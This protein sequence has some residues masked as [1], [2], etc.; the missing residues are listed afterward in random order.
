MWQ[1]VLALTDT[2]SLAAQGCGPQASRESISQ[3]Q[4]AGPGCRHSACP[5]FSKETN[6]QRKR[7]EETGEGWLQ[8][9]KKVPSTLSLRTPKIQKK[10][11]AEARLSLWLLIKWFGGFA[12]DVPESGLT[13]APIYIITVSAGP[14]RAHP[15]TAEIPSMPLPE[16]RISA[17][18]QKA[19]ETERSWVRL[20]F[21]SKPPLR[22]LVLPMEFG[23]WTAGLL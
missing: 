17:V 23:K 19:G 10:K 8:G 21:S 18:R 1:W 2:E 22:E 16:Y 14:P 6:T 7:M 11:V 5:E 12:L 20:A 4:N 3:V 9:L 13:S 15:R